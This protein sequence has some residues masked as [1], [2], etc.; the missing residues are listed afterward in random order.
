MLKKLVF[1]KPDKTVVHFQMGIFIHLHFMFHSLI[2]RVKI[3][4]TNWPAPNVKVFIAQLVEHCSANAEAMGLNPVEAP[5]CFRV[6]LQLLKLQLPLRRS[7]L[8]LKLHYRSSHHIHSKNP[9]CYE[10]PTSRSVL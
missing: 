10:K 5:K 7:Y 8:Y 6:N 1:L 9:H 4:S 3:N 2:S